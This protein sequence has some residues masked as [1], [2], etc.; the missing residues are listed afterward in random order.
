MP[1]MDGQ[2]LPLE[3]GNPVVNSRCEARRTPLALQKTICKFLR[4]AEIA[5]IFFQPGK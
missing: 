1:L 4:I 3:H 2:H 5:R